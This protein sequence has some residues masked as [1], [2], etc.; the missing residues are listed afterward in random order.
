MDVL[1]LQD[2]EEDA[3]EKEENEEDVEARELTEDACE[4]R[5]SIPT[6]APADTGIKVFKTMRCKVKGNVTLHDKEKQR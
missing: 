1:D 6:S 4:G 2:L 5:R 3:E